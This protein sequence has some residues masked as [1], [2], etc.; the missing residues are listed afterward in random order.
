M[1]VFSLVVKGFV[2]VRWQ[3]KI[4]YPI[5]LTVKG[6]QKVR[7]SYPTDGTVVW[8]GTLGSDEVFK[9]VD[10]Q[11]R[12][13]RHFVVSSVGKSSVFIPETCPVW[14]RD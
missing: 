3:V 7:E 14:C 11:D 12:V 13:F 8:E 10:E 4:V 5:C 9:V 1:F 6:G 2:G